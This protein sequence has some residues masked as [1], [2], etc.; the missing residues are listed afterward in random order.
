MVI[1]RHQF[2]PFGAPWLYN[3]HWE[4]PN[5]AKGKQYVLAGCRLVLSIVD[6]EHSGTEIR[7]IPNRRIRTFHGASGGHPK[8]LDTHLLCNIDCSP[9][10]RSSAGFGVVGVR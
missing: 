10:H 4:R 7:I 5:S 2:E 9:V 6:G 1:T 8:P 3:V